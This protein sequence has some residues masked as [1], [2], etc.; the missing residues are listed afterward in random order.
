MAVAPENR[1]RAMRPGVKV[2]IEA[3]AVVRP[4]YR[5]IEGWQT[6]AAHLHAMK[7]IAFRRGKASEGW[8]ARA[9]ALQVAVE[10]ESVGLQQLIDELP[11]D[12]RR[13]SAVHDVER[14]IGTLRKK[15]SELTAD[16]GEEPR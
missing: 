8:L 15:L 10:S 5:K 2:A 13:S 16:R 3:G 12:V 14:A 6:A 1:Q 7:D 11:P 4:M 9:S